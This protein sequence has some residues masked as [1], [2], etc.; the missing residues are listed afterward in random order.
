MNFFIINNLKV[1]K[2]AYEGY[3]IRGG[4]GKGLELSANYKFLFISPT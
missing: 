3:K 4:V 1:I 2:V